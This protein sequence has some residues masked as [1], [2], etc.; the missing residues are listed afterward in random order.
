ME[1]HGGTVSLRRATF[2]LSVARIV[3]HSANSA[4]HA[5]PQIMLNTACTLGFPPISRDASPLVSPP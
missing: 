5:P 2:G 4:I 3:E 1:D